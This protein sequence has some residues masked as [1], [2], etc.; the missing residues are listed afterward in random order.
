MPEAW[1][2]IN[3][4]LEDNVPMNNAIH[5]LNAKPLRKYRIFDQE[6]L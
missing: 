2:Y 1:I 6:L 4:V 5:K 3:Y